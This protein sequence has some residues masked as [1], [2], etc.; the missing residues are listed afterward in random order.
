MNRLLIFFVLV[1]FSVCVTAQSADFI[2]VR[3]RNGIAVKNFYPG[4][5]VSLQIKD[6][7]FAEGILHRVANDSLFIQL[8][9]VRIVPTPWGTK[10]TDTVA[11]YVTKVRYTDIGWISLGKP[12]NKL[13]TRISNMLL[14]GG[15]GG[16]VLNGIN[17][18]GSGESFFSK[19]NMGWYLTSA[20][21]FGTGFLMKK[22]IGDGGFNPRKHKIVYVRLNSN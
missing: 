7:M 5:P 9:D 20:I 19:D 14:V 3:K 10:A 17:S 2:S 8:Y 22:F 4:S 21:L 16:V 15:T 13:L 11:L 12:R 6:G 1:S 18:I